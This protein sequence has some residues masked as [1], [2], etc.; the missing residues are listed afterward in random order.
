[1][2]L[3]EWLVFCC[4]SLLSSSWRTAKQLE[5]AGLFSQYSLPLLCFA[6]VAVSLFGDLLHLCDAFI[7]FSLHSGTDGNALA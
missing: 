2:G 1:M 5:L 7:K 3:F 4:T 6:F